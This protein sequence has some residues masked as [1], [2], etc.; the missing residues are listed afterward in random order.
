MSK[1]RF[2]RIEDRGLG[3]VAVFD[4]GYPEANYN[5]GCDRQ[6]RV[7]Y[8]DGTFC[9]NESSLRVIIENVE[10]NGCDASVEKEALVELVKRNQEQKN[11]TV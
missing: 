4:R 10:A 6:P 2:L 1:L 5:Y 8:D 3:L 7:T 11:G 9:L